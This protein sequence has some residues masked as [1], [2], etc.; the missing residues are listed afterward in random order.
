MRSK[1]LFVLGSCLVS[2]AFIQSGCGTHH[3]SETNSQL[4]AKQDFREGLKALDAGDPITAEAKLKSALQNDPKLCGARV[5]LSSHYAA[6]AGITL[7]SWLTP[8]WR[9]SDG[10]SAKY[11]DTLSTA[12]LALIGQ[13]DKTV[14]EGTTEIIKIIA[15]SKV[16][17]DIFAGMPILDSEHMAIFDEAIETMRSEDFDPSLR[18]QDGRTYLALLSVI[19]LE[20]GLHKMLIDPAVDKF[21]FY[22][23]GSRLCGFDAVE[24]R[25]DLKSAHLSL[26]YLNEATIGATDSPSPQGKAFAQLRVINKPVAEASFWSDI[27]G[28]FDGKDI[29]D[30]AYRQFAVK[31]CDKLKSTIANSK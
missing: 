2:S 17:L 9:A 18:C 13:E 31:S 27:D 29:K 15:I 10:L 11:E 25:A 20:N 24:L 8:L 19:R 4:L 30:E 1:F 28:V 21:D 22:K 14:R 12:Q 3:S 16:V 7:S 26:S 5:A 23:A 6:K